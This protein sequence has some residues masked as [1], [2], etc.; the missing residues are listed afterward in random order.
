MDLERRHYINI[1]VGRLSIVKLSDNRTTGLGWSKRV[2]NCG[3]RV[4]EAAG[5]RG[6]WQ[7]IV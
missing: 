2:K 3:S 4:S 5:G 1:L 6:N 7:G